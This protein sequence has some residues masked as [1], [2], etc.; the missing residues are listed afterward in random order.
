MIAPAKGSYYQAPGRGGKKVLT[1]ALEP[2]R[3][4]SASR[5]LS[6]PRA[7]GAWREMPITPHRRSCLAFG[8]QQ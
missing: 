1:Q 4:A 2:S 5:G 8:P 7:Q 6:L 3:W